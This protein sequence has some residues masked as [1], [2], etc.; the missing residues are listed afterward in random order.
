M[1]N[2]FLL[3]AVV[4]LF[5]LTVFAADNSKPVVNTLGMK[6]VPIKAG[7]FLMGSK[8][9]EKAHQHDE[10]LHKVK[11]TKPFY[12][13]ATE[14]TQQQ[15]EK[16]MKANNS[17]F[18][19]KLLPVEKVSWKDAAEFCKK[20]SEKEDKIY[21]LPT[22]AEWEYCCRADSNEPFGG[23]E[24]DNVAWHMNNSENKTQQVAAKKPNAWGL[25]D[26]QGNVSEWCSDYYD[27]Y[28]DQPLTVDPQ[29]PEKN[30]YRVVRGG[31]WSS[32]WRA[33]RNA[34]RSSI[35]QAYQTTDMG[36]RV[37]MEISI[38]ED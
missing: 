11:I 4:C 24:Y 36:F 18:K 19:G 12:I 14:V 5:T 30:R 25:Y 8:P 13:A 22:E 6:M 15:Y 37:V 27:K 26:M 21:R 17:N 10:L 28:P 31:S 35:G 7:Q 29:G 16:V 38:K 9:T 20:L 1:K 33:C 32:S 2:I 34:A 3:P 23:M